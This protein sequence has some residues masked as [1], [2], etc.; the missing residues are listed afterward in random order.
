MEQHLV[1]SSQDAKNHKSSNKPSDFTTKYRNPI[2]LDPNKQYEVGL[3]RIISMAFTWYNVTSSLNNQLIKYSSDGGTTW[4]SLTFPAGVWS[5]EDFNIFIKSKTK[6]G[7]A[8]KPSYPISLAFDNVTFRTVIKLASG[9]QLDLRPSNFGDLIGFNKRILSTCENIS[10]YTPNLSQDREI[11]NIHCD[12]ISESLVGGS[13]TNIIYTF[14][15]DTLIPS[16]S[17]TMESRW[18][19]FSPVNKN[20][21][22]EIRI[23]IT[24]AK[25]RIIDLNHSDTSFS[26]ILREKK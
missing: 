19:Q 25:R 20:T 15:T 9:Y 7:T 16:Y 24:D 6:R 2:I 11:L 8:E 23:Y 14:S 17:F 21:I 12:L 4:T 3:H 18:V 22:S 10:D 26:L 5:Y 13:E 1:L